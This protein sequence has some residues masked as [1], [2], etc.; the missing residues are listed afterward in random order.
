MVT[1][2]Q[3]EESPRNFVTALKTWKGPQPSKE[4]WSE[5]EGTKLE[6]TEDWLG[7]GEDLQPVAQEAEEPPVSREDGAA[8]VREILEK[9]NGAKALPA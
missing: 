6:A 5:I 7:D 4:G 9:L 3:T 1:L 2:S 8:R